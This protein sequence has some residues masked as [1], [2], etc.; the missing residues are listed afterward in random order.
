MK[1][2]KK[3]LLI[4]ALTFTIASTSSLSVLAATHTAKAGDTYWKISTWYGVTLEDLLKANGAT[5]TSIL[6][7]GQKVYI[8]EKITYKTHVVQKGEDLWQLSIKYGITVNDIAKANNISTNKVLY[9]G[10]VLKIPV[11]NVPVKSTPGPQYGELLDWWTEA[12]YLLPINAEFKVTDF[13]TG[14]SFWVKRTVGASHIDAETLTL[15]DTNT[16]KSIWG[17]TLSWVRRPVIIEY[18]GRKIAASMTSAPH[19]GNEHAP[20]GAYSTWRSGGYGAG[21]NYDYVK[22]NGIDGHFD[23]HFLNSTRHSD[24]KVDTEH[25]K[26]VKIAAGV[27]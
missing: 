16:M 23:I 3:R 14:K 22:G 10:D 27:K 2:L 24:G 7:I 18:N 13:Y 12:Q 20:G 4:G 26:N 5:Y 9:I 6:Y 11:Y 15:K 1:K 17:G 19:A 21:T 8:P 25:Q